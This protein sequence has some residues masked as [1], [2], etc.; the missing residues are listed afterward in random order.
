MGNGAFAD[1]DARSSRPGIGRKKGDVLDRGTFPD[2]KFKRYVQEA[3]TF[4][5]GKQ[6]YKTSKDPQG[7]DVPKF[8]S[9]VSWD[10]KP[11]WYVPVDGQEEVWVAEGRPEW[12]WSVVAQ[13]VAGYRKPSTPDEVA[14][15]TEGFR[16]VFAACSNSLG[17][18]APAVI[19]DMARRIRYLGETGLGRL[20][21][22][23]PAQPAGIRLEDLVKPEEIGALDDEKKAKDLRSKLEAGGVQFNPP[24]G[25]PNPAGSRA[26]TVALIED[27]RG[28]DPPTKVEYQL[29]LRANNH[30]KARRH[31]LAHE[32]MHAHSRRGSGLQ[33]GGDL[34]VGGDQVD[35][36]YTEFLAR[37]VTDTITAVE[38]GLSADDLKEP[39]G[40]KRKELAEQV[41]YNVFCCES[42]EADQAKGA[43]RYQSNIWA[44][45]KAFFTGDKSGSQPSALL[46]AELALYLERDAGPL[47]TELD[48]VVGDPGV[49][50]TAR[51][52]GGEEAPRGGRAEP[53]PLRLELYLPGDH[54]TDY[55][56]LLIPDTAG[57]RTRSV[58]ID[59]GCSGGP[60][61]AKTQQKRLRALLD[62]LPVSGGSRVLDQVIITSG[63][64]RR[65]NLLPAVTKGMK[66]QSVHYAGPLTGSK[67]PVH[68]GG[69]IST[70]LT[71]SGAC[72]F[73]AGLSQPDQ[74]FAVLGPAALYVLG[75][76]LGADS[77]GGS[78]VLMVA[79]GRL[80][81]VLTSDA[82]AAAA[83]TV[84]ALC[85]T[86]ANARIFGSPADITVITGR[87]DR[88]AAGQW[89]WSAPAG[90]PIPLPLTH[91]GRPL[92]GVGGARRVAAVPVAPGSLPRT[93][94]R[95]RLAG[96]TLTFPEPPS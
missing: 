1:D 9:T 94:V 96:T 21:E 8:G 4:S 82:S 62:R 49:A 64:A 85:T 37:M 10:T 78:A 68:G 71:A 2:P 15:L 83:R 54:D 22:I 70:W 47:P 5:E 27:I 88:H 14:M 46:K 63:A 66:I 45:V 67:A 48:V 87:P 13:A 6:N 92:G 18:T 11:Y 19:P 55:H 35:E 90:N 34:T 56:L 20:L 69:V 36:A 40:G 42:R 57:G 76:N 65:F 77:T 26:R 28:D 29:T 86:T 93:T 61:T 95:A 33:R 38:R 89:P 24:P 39:K 41:Q 72:A 12:Y 52:D 17:I 43:L 50:R 74:P 75:A 16:V 60:A 51:A 7:K 32:F 81:L 31:L 58:L 3:S 23:R 25:T 59:G 84:A 79:L 53:K 73:P 80:R 91:A 44:L 30:A